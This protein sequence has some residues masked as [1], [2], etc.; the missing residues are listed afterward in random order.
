MKLFSNVVFGDIADPTVRAK[1]QARLE[2]DRRDEDR[3]L[4]NPYTP[5][6]AT[7][8]Q[9]PAQV[10][11]PRGVRRA[12][13]RADKSARRRAR[14]P[15][16]PAAS[17][18]RQE[19]IPYVVPL[20]EILDDGTTLEKAGITVWYR[21]P[22]FRWEF[23]TND[24]RQAMLNEVARAVASLAGHQIHLR[25]THRPVDLDA[26]AADLDATAR[27]ADVDAW[28]EQLGRTADTIAGRGLGEKLAFIGVHLAG[29][30][31]VRRV[32]AAAKRGGRAER[33]LAE[34][35]AAAAEIDAAMRRPGIDAT[36]ATHEEVVWLTHR[37]VGLHLPGAPAEVY[38]ND[39]AADE[40]NTFTDG[41]EIT[42]WK[43]Q[44]VKLTAQ[45]TRANDSDPVDRFIA[46]LSLGRMEKLRI[47]EVHHP[48]L[49]LADML[50]FPVEVSAHFDVLTGDQARGEIT[51]KLKLI[52]DQQAQLATHGID[53]D[54]E[55]EAVRDQ[56]ARAAHDMDA[57][58]EVDAV[59]LK[60]QVRFAVAAPT[61]AETLQR[62]RQ[63]RDRYKD[64]RVTI[65][66]SDAQVGLL[67]EFVPGSRR[68]SAAYTR[69]GN[70][71]WFAAAVPN[72]D[73]GIGD[74]KGIYLGGT[75]SLGQPVL[76]DPFAAM[77]QSETTGLTSL[78]AEPGGGK[79]AL[80]ARVAYWLTL[81]GV[82][83]TL[84]DPS[85][86]LARLTRIPE[87]RDVS[88]HVDLATAPPGSL[89]PFAVIPMPRPDQYS[90][91]G[92]YE[93]AALRVAGERSALARDVVKMLLPPSA[94]HA[95]GTELVL[96]EA[97]D[98]VRKVREPHLGHIITELDRIHIAGGDLA[99]TARH[100][101]IYL[102]QAAE[103]PLGRLMFANDTTHGAALNVNRTLVVFTMG[104]L[105]LPSPDSD[106]TYWTEQERFAV[107]LLH[108]A[109][110]AT[111]RRIYNQP[112]STRKFVGLDECHWLAGWPSGRALWTRLARDSR[113]WHTRVIAASQIPEDVAH[114][115]ALVGEAF[116]GILT[117]ARA[118]QDA[119]ALMRVD[120]SYGP[121]L[122]HLSPPLSDGSDRDYREFWFRD[123]Y[124]R[125][126]QI[127]VTLDDCPNLA[128]ALDPDQPL[129]EE[130]TP[131]APV[132]QP[133]PPA[134]APAEPAHLAEDS[135]DAAAVA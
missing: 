42:P 127:Y 53:D 134:A 107:P 30:R 50:P 91:P 109:V 71:D 113:K 26:W 82:S 85:G 117:D 37:S 38:G 98:A 33:E 12:A 68:V 59:R 54:P 128:L 3:M 88:A 131:P 27:P 92:A 62:V 65:A 46:V 47:P 132:R 6:A 96:A 19:P 39:L 111:T 90:D 5:P 49:A 17:R 41:V 84:F 57:G 56:A 112:M 101:G 28:R 121:D 119:C 120:G 13:A 58:D 89:N 35:N 45:P 23:T 60:G 103:Q 14:R 48:W 31:K 108:L 122:A 135:D 77:I 16:R 1:Y 18:R 126:G 34:I 118:Q 43:G 81:M 83:C 24:H 74:P 73:M 95:E 97:F 29:R 70:T 44:L 86:P 22:H 9:Q 32:L 110:A 76:W 67:R 66:H 123:R 51:H 11:A 133:R 55:L 72:L 80:L 99:Q 69:R 40:M 8:Q 21:L 4:G 15:I 125:V 104:G 130:W 7:L 116:T 114:T 52:R 20:E 115:S 78:V 63:L 79:S 61:P 64:Y 36:R 75:S 25:V 2:R 102:R 124:G 100:L 105:V 93:E 106:P 87:L 129:P 94:L 10:P